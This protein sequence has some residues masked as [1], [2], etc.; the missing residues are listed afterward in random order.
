[1]E[2]KDTLEWAGALKIL[3]FTAHAC[4]LFKPT[5]QHMKLPAALQ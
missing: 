2:C 1:M 4:I 3:Y 5:L